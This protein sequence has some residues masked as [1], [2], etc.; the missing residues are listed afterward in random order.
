MTLVGK[1]WMHW[2]NRATGGENTQKK[3]MDVLIMY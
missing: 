1:A 2:K 3:V